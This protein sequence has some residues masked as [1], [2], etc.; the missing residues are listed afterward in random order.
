MLRLPSPPE[1][2]RF[3]ELRVGDRVTITY[4]QSTIYHLIGRHARPPKVSEQIAATESASPLPGATFSHQATERVTVTN[5]DRKAASITVINSSG[6]TVTR[7]VDN[8]SDLE[9]VSKGDHIDITYTQAVL[10]TV[11]RPN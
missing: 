1:F 4:Y 10:A 11:T 3:N 2:T 7:H 9:G 6:Q 5:I 8:P